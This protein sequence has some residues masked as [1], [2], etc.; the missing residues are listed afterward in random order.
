[1]LSLQ[2]NRIISAQVKIVLLVHQK[3]KNQKEKKY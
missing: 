3:L 2:D 1:M